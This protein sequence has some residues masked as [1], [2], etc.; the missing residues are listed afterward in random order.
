MSVGYFL[1]SL[2]QAFSSRCFYLP[3]GSWSDRSVV[4]NPN[5]FLPAFVSGFLFRLAEYSTLSVA[6]FN[7]R[8]ILDLASTA[9]DSNLILVNAELYSSNN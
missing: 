7:I 2:Y 8:Y 1:P 9:I 4:V 5:I 3:R 6:R